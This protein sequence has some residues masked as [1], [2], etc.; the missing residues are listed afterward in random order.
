MPP[1]RSSPKNSATKHRWWQ[2]ATRLFSVV[3]KGIIRLGQRFATTIGHIRRR[4]RLLAIILL[5]VWVVLL[6]GNFYIRGVSRFEGSLI[7][8]VMSFTYAGDV[9]KRFLNSIDNILKLSL[10]GEQK[11]S[12][13]LDGKFSSR[14]PDL[15]KKLES[16]SKLKIQLTS[17]RSRLTLETADAKQP[18]I[19]LLEMQLAPKTQIA[20]LTYL[21]KASQLKLCMESSQSDCENSSN[22]N[23]NQAIVGKLGFSV[24]QSPLNLFISS[25]N[26][27]TLG[28]DES[29][30]ETSLRW[31]P[32][33]QDFTVLL[34]S[35]T[36]LQIS[37]PKAYK[38]VAEEMPDDLTR[39]IRGDIPVRDV[40]F[41][42]LDRTG[43]TNDD[44]ETS[45]ILDGEVRMM[46]QSLKLQPGQFLIIPSDRDFDKSNCRMSPTQNPGIQRL[47]DIRLNT[48]DPQGL[49]TLFSG[50]SKCLAIGLYERFPTQSIEPS[51][52]LKYLPQEGI[53]AIYTLIGA[54]TGILFPRLF[55]D[56]DD[57]KA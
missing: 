50:E 12:L 29:S 5:L 36:S 37:L 15:N 49:Q 38:P 25:A 40:S 16:L 18:A 55:P 7:T 9:N 31:T 43:N 17:P 24:A 14:D 54:F 44:I 6:L 33:A 35:P 39:S 34:R 56:E 26:I 48:K 47:R 45:E 11:D 42:N 53:N 27:P 57:P 20:G 10:Q 23:S 30:L 1:S 8:R 52:L 13:V 32:E 51:W 22:V 2:R 21:A 28:V 4:D 3:W 41:S 46:G 19:S